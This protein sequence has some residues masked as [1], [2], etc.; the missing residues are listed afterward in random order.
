M[1][2]ERVNVH[3]PCSFRVKGASYVETN[4]MC[5]D[6]GHSLTASQIASPEAHVDFYLTPTCNTVRTSSAT[7]RTLWRSHISRTAVR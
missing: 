4:V 2:K 3:T 7:M 6:C 1:N 5:V